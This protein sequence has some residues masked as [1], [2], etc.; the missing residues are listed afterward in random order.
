MNDEIK[1]IRG[2]TNIFDLVIFDNS[3]QAYELKDGDKIVFGVKKIPKVQ[4]MT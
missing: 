2:T 3:E 4:T 1:I